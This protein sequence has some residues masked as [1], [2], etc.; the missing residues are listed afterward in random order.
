MGLMCTSVTANPYGHAVN[1]CS[2][3]AVAKK[4]KV[5]KPKKEKAAKPAAKGEHLSL[6]TPLLLLLAT[7]MS[8]LAMRLK[9]KHAPR[10]FRS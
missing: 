10:S 3:A 7:A 6:S 2:L 5:E 1:A 9:P 8:M 4:P